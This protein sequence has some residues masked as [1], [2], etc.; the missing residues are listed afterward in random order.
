MLPRYLEKLK[1]SNLLHFV[2]TQKRATF[3]N[4]LYL[5]YTSTD[6]DNFCA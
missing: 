2:V 4:R 3:F 5:P 1:F 6:F